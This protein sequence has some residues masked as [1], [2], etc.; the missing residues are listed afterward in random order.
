MKKRGYGADAQ[1][2]DEFHHALRVTSGQQQEGYYSDFN[3]IVHLAKSYNDAYVYDGQFS[4]HRKKFFGTKTNNPGK[5]FVVFS[6]N[7]DQI[8][9]RMLGE[10]TST[11]VSTEMCKLLAAAVLTAPY[12]PMLFMG[13]EWA[14]SNPFLFFINHTDEALA[15]LVNK[16]R[17]EEFAYF[18]WSGEPPDPRLEETFNNSLLQWN[19][20]DKE[21]HKS[22][23]KFY[24]EL[25][26][27][28]KSH[29]ALKY[30]DRSRSKASADVEKENINTGKMER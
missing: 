14:E 27:L 23:H 25:I 9:N 6:Q 7:H 2:I 24:K 28:R 26:A 16:G 21:P 11:L 15:A 1:W 18:N 29:P 12:L 4:G 3:G 10:R 22:M 17:K 20:L 19:L 5:Q 30:P 13:E 8:G